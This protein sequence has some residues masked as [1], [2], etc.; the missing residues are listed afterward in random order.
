MNDDANRGADTAAGVNLSHRERSAVC[1]VLSVTTLD[2]Q[3]A[4][5]VTPEEAAF[6]ADGDPR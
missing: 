5:F 6:A 2:T 4:K 1:L 3:L